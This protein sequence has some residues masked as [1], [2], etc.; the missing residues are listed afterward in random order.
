MHLPVGG[1]LG[2]F[3]DLAIVNSAAMKI[4]VH[5]SFLIMVF[6]VYMS[7]SGIT[8]SYHR[9][10]FLFFKEFHTVLHTAVPVDIPTNSV[11]RFPFLHSFYS[12]YYL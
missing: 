4:G 2:C 9:S 10:I 12:I 3:H 6:S 8:E 5:V 11:E 7:R 1:H